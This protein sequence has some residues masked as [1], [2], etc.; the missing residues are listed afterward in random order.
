MINRIRALLIALAWLYP[1]IW[2]AFII[3]Y[4]LLSLW[5]FWTFFGPTHWSP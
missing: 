2:W 4:L 1:A 3:G 5:F